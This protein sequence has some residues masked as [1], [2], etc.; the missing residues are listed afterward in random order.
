MA[1]TIRTTNRSI[2]RK[3]LQE[4]CYTRKLSKKGKDRFNTYWVINSFWKLRNCNPKTK[5]GSSYCICC[6]REF[7]E[8]LYLLQYI[9][10]KS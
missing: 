7:I 9:V 10:T 1:S 5:E 3:I 4:V 6:N 2:A 8:I